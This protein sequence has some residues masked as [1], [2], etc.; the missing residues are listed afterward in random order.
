MKRISVMLLAVATLAVATIGCNNAGGSSDPKAVLMAFSEKLGKKDFEGA[1][2]LATKESAPVIDLMQKAMKMAEKFAGMVPTGK[3]KQDA[4]FE[5][6]KI[7]EPRIE[8][9]YAY[10]PLTSSGSETIEY[11]LKNEGGAWK[12][13]FTESTMNKMGMNVKDL[14]EAEK[15]MKEMDNMNMDS[16]TKGMEGMEGMEGMKDMMKPENLKKMQ[17]QAKEMQK[18]GEDAKKQIE[19]MKQ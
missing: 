9:N 11:V 4:S 15:G 18:M 14:E 1:K 6:V 13:D 7:G 16:L 17:E 10:L 5:N 3:E 8:G 19:S 12:V 2:A